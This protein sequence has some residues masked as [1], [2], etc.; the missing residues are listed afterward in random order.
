LRKASKSTP[1][2][3]FRVGVAH[4]VLFCRLAVIGVSFTFLRLDLP[5]FLNLAFLGFLALAVDAFN[6]FNA[7]ISFS[8]SLAVIFPSR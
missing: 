7:L 4:N 8:A 1:C 2:G 6:A 5:N 3:A